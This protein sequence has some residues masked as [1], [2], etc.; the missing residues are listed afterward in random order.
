MLYNDLRFAPDH[1][2]DDSDVA[3]DDFDYDVRDVFSDVDVDWCAVVVVGVHR[4]C[5]VD[6][7]KK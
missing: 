4:D 3:L 5:G 1:F 6:S 2:V 7:L